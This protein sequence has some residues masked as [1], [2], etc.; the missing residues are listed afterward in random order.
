MLNKVMMSYYLMGIKEPIH[1][2]SYA[3]SALKKEGSVKETDY[4]LRPQ[5]KPCFSTLVMTMFICNMHGQLPNQVPHNYFWSLQ[6]FGYKE[7][8]E[9]IFF[10]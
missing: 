2:A 9:I 3:S 10:F 4:T 8:N 7:S 6:K 5:D 1:W